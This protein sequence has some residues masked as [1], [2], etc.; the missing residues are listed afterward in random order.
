MTIETAAIAT[1]DF[2]GKRMLGAHFGSALDVICQHLLH[3]IKYFRLYDRLMG[4]AD[5]DRCH[6]AVILSDLFGEI[7]HGIGLLK[8]FFITEDAA[9]SAD[10]PFAL[11]CWR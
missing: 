10:T 3:Q 9:D 5:E 4:M 2:A 8:L 11:S 6:F 7:I 1:D